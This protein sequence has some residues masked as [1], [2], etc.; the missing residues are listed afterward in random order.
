MLGGDNLGVTNWYWSLGIFCG[1]RSLGRVV[2]FLWGNGVGVLVMVCS[3][4]FSF[5]W[6]TTSV[7][8]ITLLVAAY[9]FCVSFW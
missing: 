9:V 6:T 3:T 1:S 5:L 8:S 4:V 2:M 7:I